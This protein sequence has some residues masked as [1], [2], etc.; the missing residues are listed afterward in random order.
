MYPTMA[1]LNCTSK[2][3]K[4][5]GGNVFVVPKQENHGQHRSKDTFIRF[6]FH[7]V[8]QDTEECVTVDI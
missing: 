7:F 3:K 4:S 5:F 2:Q 8:Y 1:N 6:D